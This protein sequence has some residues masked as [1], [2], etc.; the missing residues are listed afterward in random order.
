[1][2]KRHLEQH[3]E[4]GCLHNSY[5]INTDNL[6]S[7]LAEIEEFI[8]STLLKVDN[9]EHSADYLVLK[10]LDSKT[11]IIAVDQVRQM[12]SFLYKTSV[13]TGK[14]VAVIYGADQMNL[15]AANSCLKI[16]E[17]TP[18]NTYLFLIT[19]NAASILPTIRSR[20]AKINHHYD[21]AAHYEVEERFIKPLLKSSSVSER[22]AFIKEFASKDR[23]LWVDF[24][25]AAERLL[26]KFCHKMIDAQIDLSPL[27]HELLSQFKSNF[28]PKLQVKYSKV[29]KIIDD[30]NNFDLD[31]RASC[32]LIAEEFRS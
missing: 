18:A 31:L 5:L 12:Q 15:N 30:T 11:K 4:I 1:M 32:A 19:E 6:I 20:C 13:I 28:P 7:A 14:K 21:E 22:L 9:L 25:I 26:A 10:R 16:L 2:I 17:D 3:N 27:E 29:Q 23:D 24:S 8:A